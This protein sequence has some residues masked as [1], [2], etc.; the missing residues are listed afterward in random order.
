MS[1][2]VIGLGNHGGSYAHT[3]H[4][5]GWMVLD[6]LERRG[7]FAK[8]RREGPARVTEGSVDGVDLL[9]ARPQTYMNLSGRAG[10]HLTNRF[11]VAPADVIVVHD[12]LDLPVG[13][14]RLRR[15]G[16]AGGQRGVQSL[17]DSWR[18]KD[19]MRV[20]IGIGR[21]PDDE[22]PTDYVLRRFKPDEKELIAAAIPRAADAVLDIVRVGLEKAASTYNAVPKPPRPPRDGDENSVPE[23]AARG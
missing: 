5:L 18:F 14:L 3:R 1:Q 13:R 10:V 9:L 12:D 17:I 22:D 23:Q 6:E 20:R 8:E 2:L 21:P 16:S 7:R 19:F 4:N 11:N 15:G